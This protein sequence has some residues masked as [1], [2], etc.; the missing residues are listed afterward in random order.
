[1]PNKVRLSPDRYSKDGKFLWSSGYPL[2]PCP[3][4]ERETEHWYKLPPGMKLATRNPAKFL[5]ACRVCKKS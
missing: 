5:W 1:M 2:A 4:C 3:H